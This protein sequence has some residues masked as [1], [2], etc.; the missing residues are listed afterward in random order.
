MELFTCP[1]SVLNSH[2]TPKSNR[3]SPRSARGRILTTDHTAPPSP[4][5]R[6]PKGLLLNLPSLPGFSRASRCFPQALPSSWRLY[7]K[8][9]LPG[10]RLQQPEPSRSNQRNLLVLLLSLATRPLS[11][12]PPAPQLCSSH[13]APCPSLPHSAQEPKGC[14]PG[15]FQSVTPTP[16]SQRGLHHLP[17]NSLFSSS[18]FTFLQSTDGL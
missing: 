15:R 5:Q 11:Q 6:R 4:I 18:C 9:L 16:P 2:L 17:S 14:S 10:L 12:P 7:C 1:V 13:T 8:S 3:L